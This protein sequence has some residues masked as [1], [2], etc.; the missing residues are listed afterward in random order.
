MRAPNNQFFDAARES[1]RA[2]QPVVAWPEDCGRYG[3]G[4][5]PII[6]INS[7]CLYTRWDLIHVQEFDPYVKVNTRPGRA[8][9]RYESAAPGSILFGTFEPRDADAQTKCDQV[10]DTTSAYAEGYGDAAADFESVVKN[11][12]AAYDAAFDE[13][14]GVGEHDGFDR[15]AGQFLDGWLLGHKAKAGHPDG[16]P[17]PCGQPV[18]VDAVIEAFEEEGEAIPDE[19]LHPGETI[20]YSDQ[21]DPTSWKTNMNIEPFQGS[22]PKEETDMSEN[23]FE[24]TTCTPCERI[25]Y[26]RLVYEVAE[27]QAMTKLVEPI[28]QLVGPEAVEVFE[29]LLGLQD[30]T[31][32]IFTELANV[33]TSERRESLEKWLDNVKHDTKKLQSQ[34][35][36]MLEGGYD[37]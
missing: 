7:P 35:E 20:L 2:N 33:E 22:E 16:D 36:E 12:S 15:C 24:N 30:E 5:Y 37:V 31:I 23:I 34:L 29:E 17:A 13:G 27:L 6:D 21:Q 25:K 28:A 19:E 32:E 4:A 18:T 1:E 3:M 14:Y 10:E 11:A 8:Y 26:A 9:A